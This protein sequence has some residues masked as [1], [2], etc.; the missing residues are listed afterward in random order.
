MNS[1][2]NQDNSSP[3]RK[4]KIAIKRD[5]KLVLEKAKE[6]NK[7]TMVEVESYR[8]AGNPRLTRERGNDDFKEERKVIH[9]RPSPNKNFVKKEV[10][11]NIEL[12]DQNLEQYYL[13]FNVRQEEGDELGV[14]YIIDKNNLFYLERV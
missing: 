7:G 4:P 5:D 12:I 6:E 3:K 1:E 10:Q 8:V 2:N 9:K 13:N 11:E 14:S